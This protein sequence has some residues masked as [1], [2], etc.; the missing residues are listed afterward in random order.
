MGLIQLIVIVLVVWLVWRGVA[1]F[2]ARVA[3]QTPT[4]SD[5]PT[6]QQGGVM[7]LCPHCGVHFPAHLAV[8][9]QGR[10]YC[11]QTCANQADRL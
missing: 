10:G 7:Q 11:S 2:K 1:Q 3:A 6:L 4:E 8:V 9:K 5:S